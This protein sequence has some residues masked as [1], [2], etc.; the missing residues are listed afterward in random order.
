M[1]LRS[2]ETSWV[3]GIVVPV[4]RIL[5]DIA[6][7]VLELA[8]V[9]DDPIVIAALPDGRT[10]HAPDPVHPTRRVGLESTDDFEQRGALPTADG[11]I[12]KHHDSMDVISGRA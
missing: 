6:A 10:A 2:A 5:S 1:L 11:A 7:D 3:L 8:F 12:A 4:R 9:S